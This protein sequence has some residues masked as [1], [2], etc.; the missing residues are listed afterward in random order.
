M[1]I[2]GI[3]LNRK[4]LIVWV[5]LFIV[6]V[7]I[8][9]TGITHEGVWYD[10]ACSIGIIRHPIISIWQVVKGDVHPPL[11]FFMLKLFTLLFGN[12]VFALRTF[13][14]LGILALFLLG[15]GPVRRT[16]GKTVGLLF[17]F[18]VITTPIYLAIAQEIRMYSWAVFLVTGSVLYAYLA[19]SENKKSDWLKFGVLMFAAMYT[20]YHALAAMVILDGLIVLRFLK[21]TKT[22]TRV[23][24]GI[25]AALVALGFLPWLGSLI[26]QM[27]WVSWLPPVNGETIWY[28]LIYPYGYKIFS[29]D[30]LAIISFW[31]ILGLICWGI[32]FATFKHNEAKAVLLAIEVYV[33]TFLAAVLFS[34]IFWPIF[35]TKHLL[36]ISGLMLL[37]AAYGLAQVPN[38]KIIAVF[39]VIFLGLMIP[40]IVTINQ[41]RFNGPVREITDYFTKNLKPD[42]VFIHL[43]PESWGVFSYYFSGNQQFIY[44]IHTN[45][46]FAYCKTFE[47]NGI[48]GSDLAGFLQDKH[49]HHIWLI[50]ENY[51]PQNPAIKIFSANSIIETKVLKIPES[52]FTVR[53]NKIKTGN[54]P[55]RCDL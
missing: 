34:L 36:P 3:I 11:Y 15:I 20:H 47:P 52:W 8:L 32:G 55:K 54:K 19:I 50:D 2:K 35:Q 21:T 14:V 29:E 43:E 53:I 40:H 45:P 13:S 27:H 17:S 41:S 51:E 5:V 30:P 48:G 26:R 22:R 39:V 16:C 46:G 44:T 37:A 1:K 23:V 18:L 10:E 4:E 38:K 7:I 24:F 42:D 33:L 49:P 31:L 25:S 12:S 28:T 6:E 9:F